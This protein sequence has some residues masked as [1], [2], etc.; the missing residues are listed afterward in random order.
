MGIVRFLPECGRMWW[1][2]RELRPGQGERTSVG[3]GGD[4]SVKEMAWVGVRKSRGRSVRRG[5]V[6]RFMVGEVVGG[7]VVGG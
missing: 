5:A 2:A 3:P 7:W 4:Q 1:F 6:R